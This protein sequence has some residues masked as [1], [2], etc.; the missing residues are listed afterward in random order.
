MLGTI[1]LPPHRPYIFIAWCLA[2]SRCTILTFTL[3]CVFISSSFV[4][5]L[6]L[7]ISLFIHA[8][9][10]LFSFLFVFLS[11]DQ[12]KE[13]EMGRVCSTNGGDEECM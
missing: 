13:D 9:L 2:E 8:F 11:F 6:A 10:Y 1:D 5:H 3:L 12:V 4:P 7:L